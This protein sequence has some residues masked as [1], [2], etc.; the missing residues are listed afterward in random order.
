MKAKTDQL[1]SLLAQSLKPVYLIAG[2]EPLLVQECRDQI[3]RAAQQQG[4]MERELYQ[5]AARFDWA[6]IKESSENCRCPSSHRQ[7]GP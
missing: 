6:M 2:A 4:F 3:I 7:T 1:P 5:A